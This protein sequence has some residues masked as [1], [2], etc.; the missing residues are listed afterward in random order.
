MNKKK[1]LVLSGLV[2]VLVFTFT[3]WDVIVHKDYIDAFS[4]ATPL[5]LEK[6]VPA[7]LKL[8]IDGKV[9]KQYEFI[10]SSFRLLAKSRIRIPEITSTGEILGA[11]IYTGI[12]MYYIMEGVAPLKTESDAFDRPLDMIVVFTSS[13][14]KKVRFSYGELTMASDSHPIM[15]AYHREPVLPSKDPET[16]TRNTLDKNFRGL[17]LVC[18]GERDNARF[19]DDVVR[20]TLE[21]PNIPDELIPPMQKKKKCTSTAISCIYAGNVQP[22]DYEGVKEI[23]VSHWFRTGHGRGIKGERPATASG[24]HLA[25][26]LKH[27]FQDCGPDDFYLFVGCDGYRVLLSGREIFCT[28]A[29]DTFMLLKSLNG[30]PPKGGHTLGPIADFFVDRD[31]WGLS[32]IVRL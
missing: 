14:G 22:A 23:T 8:V 29:G 26:F 31:V 16:Y 32:H 5:A 24:Y 21:I 20:I 10:R 17:R 13:T 19:L 28:S 3:M 2:L 11:Y 4:G 9:K 30:N 12:P 25:S 15:L 18:P 27:N 1:W 7:G 6:E